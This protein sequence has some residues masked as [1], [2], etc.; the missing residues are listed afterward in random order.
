[1]TAGV[2]RN[3]V[4]ARQPVNI[5]LSLINNSS[6]SIGLDALVL[7]VDDGEQ[8]KKA[9]GSDNQPSSEETRHDALQ[10][11]TVKDFTAARP[12]R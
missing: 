8:M 5:E 6:S 3:I 1:M 10:V 4:D 2:W 9:E 11:R 12:A 7:R